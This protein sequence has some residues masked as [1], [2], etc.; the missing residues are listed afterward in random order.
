MH[1]AHKAFNLFKHSGTGNRKLFLNEKQ[2][3]ALIR[4]F[5]G[6]RIPVPLFLSFLLM[7]PTR[8][9]L[10]F[11]AGA[12]SG[13]KKSCGFRRSGHEGTADYVRFCE[14]NAFWL[15]DYALFMTV[16]ESYGGRSLTE[17]EAPVR[18][19][20]PEALSK[21][22]DAYAET[23]RFH[24]WEQYTFTCQWKAL[25][26][27]ANEAGVRIIGDI[28]IYVSADSADFW[29]HRDLFFLDE[30]GRIRMV[31]GVPPVCFSADGQLWGNPLYDWGRHAKTGYDWWIRKTHFP[32]R[33]P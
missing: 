16:K 21:L 11:H 7:D 30:R 2:I 5:P 28:P 3:G 12:D 32:G 20:D 24:K 22:G 13:K 29:A 9:K 27:Y 14:D 18:E 23:I 33:A 15:E 19:R 17:W 8:K 6:F 10:F 26:D 1:K 31:A 4:S 25:K